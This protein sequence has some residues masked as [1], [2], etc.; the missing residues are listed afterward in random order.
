MFTSVTAGP[1]TNLTDE[2]LA[3]RDAVAAF[4]EGEVRPRVAAMEAAAKIDSTLILKFFEMGLMGIQVPEQLGGA[5]GSLMM[6]TLAVEEISKVCGSTGLT[7]AMRT[8]VVGSKS[9]PRNRATASR[10]TCLW[11]DDDGHSDS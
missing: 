4:A 1:L 10:F 11:S 5:G 9:V 8:S 3:F 2:E 6:T 7:L